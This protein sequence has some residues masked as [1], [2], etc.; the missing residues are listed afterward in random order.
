MSKLLV[1]KFAIP[2]GQQVVEFDEDKYSEENNC[3]L[4][5]KDIQVTNECII[6]TYE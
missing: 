2:D 5:E 1:L 4:V 6:I 3:T